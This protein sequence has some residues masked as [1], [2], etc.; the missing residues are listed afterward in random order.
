MSKLDAIIEEFQDLEARD[1]LELLLDFAEKLAE[2]SAAYQA[3]RDAGLHRVPECMTPTFLW[4]E[5]ISGRVSIHAY[6]APEAP[7][8][9][10]FVSILVEAFNGTMSDE[11]VSAPA[12]LLHR[13]GLA[14]LLGMN[15]LRGL[16]AV[17]QRL[18][19]EIGKASVLA[20]KG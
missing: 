6:V 7:T 18:K 4:V 17:Q 12:D 14:E 13:L 5:C 15:R 8:V 3:E 16:N 2:L 1:R 11:V 10:G 19:N 20:V 9:K